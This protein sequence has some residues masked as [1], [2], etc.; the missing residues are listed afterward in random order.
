[1]DK[2]YRLSVKVDASTNML[3]V[4]STVDDAVKKIEGKLAKLEETASRTTASFDAFSRAITRLSFVAVPA[5]T[6]AVKHALKTGMNFEVALKDLSALT[7]MTGK[8]LDSLKN[9]ALELSIAYGLSADNIV[10]GM[11]RIASNRSELMKV[12]GA[13]ERVSDSAAVLARASGLTF[14]RSGEVITAT[15]NQ[16]KLGLKDTGR[17]INSF[18]EAARLGSFEVDGL[19]RV[20][21]RAGGVLNMAG[22]SF[23]DALSVSMVAS[24][25]GLTSEMVGTQIKTLYARLSS[26][27]DIFNP[28]VVGFQEAMENLKKA[29]LTPAAIYAIMGMESAQVGQQLLNNVALTKKWA[30]A[31]EG[32]TTAQ[33]QAKKNM[34]AQEKTLKRIRSELNRVL[35]EWYYTEDVQERIRNALEWIMHLFKQDTVGARFTKWTA[36]WAAWLVV[37]LLVGNALWKVYKAFKFIKNLG[38][39]ALL[40]EGIKELNLISK[41]ATGSGILTYLAAIGIAIGT[42]GTTLYETIKGFVQNWDK[43]TQLFQEGKWKQLGISV[44]KLF[45]SGFMRGMLT[46]GKWIAKLFAP[47]MD[48]VIWLKT[49]EKNAFSNTLDKNYKELYAWWKDWGEAGLPSGKTKHIPETPSWASRNAVPNMA[50]SPLTDNTFN[51]NITTDELA[52]PLVNSE[53]SDSVGI[54]IPVKP[55]DESTPFTFGGGYDPFAR[56]H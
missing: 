3:K 35:I 39:F 5:F 45:V 50:T 38:V 18:A 48:W 40:L 44:A 33:K 9:K 2:H 37:I 27:D 4:A 13:I 32:T 24:R 19:S 21:A 56:W 25:I 34:E 17:I 43:L 11:K 20:L 36:K 52:W 12:E 28:L 49:G 6:M 22:A 53:S 26:M 51:V 29:N 54:T 42:I 47:L 16:F 46:L 10:A 31:I 23:E 41:L 15:M 7:G 8:Q 30:K 55:P 14:Y 1:M